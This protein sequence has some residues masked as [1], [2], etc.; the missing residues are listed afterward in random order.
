MSGELVKLISDIKVAKEKLEELYGYKGYTD[1]EVL[2]QGDKV[3]RLIN[4]YARMVN[5]HNPLVLQGK[6]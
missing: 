5:Q 4:K 2:K 1:F 3:D 6:N